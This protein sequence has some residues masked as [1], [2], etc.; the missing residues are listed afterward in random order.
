[1]VFKSL[2]INLLIKSLVH[3][4]EKVLVITVADVASVSNQDHAHAADIA[5]AHVELDTDDEDEIGVKHKVVA[6]DNDQELVETFDN[7]FTSSATFRTKVTVVH[8]IEKVGGDQ[9]LN[10]DGWDWA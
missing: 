3:F 7:E 2:F 10:L 8:D 6:Y 4:P 1:M 5:V 9:E